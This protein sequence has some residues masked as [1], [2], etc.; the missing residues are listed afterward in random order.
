M[1]REDGRRDGLEGRVQGGARDGDDD[2]GDEHGNN[3]DCVH[4][5]DLPYHCGLL[6]IIVSPTLCSLRDHPPTYK[7]CAHR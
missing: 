7:D 4:K 6:N 2:D 3:N 5:I 1:G